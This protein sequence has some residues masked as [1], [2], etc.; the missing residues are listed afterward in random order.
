LILRPPEKQTARPLTELSLIVDASRFSKKIAEFQLIIFD[1]YA[2]QGVLPLIYFDNI[3]K[4]VRDGGAVLIAAGPLCKPDQH[5]GPRWMAFCL[6]NR[7]AILTERSF[8]PQLPMPAAAI[9]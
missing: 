6:P 3:A 2:R 9:R 1:R 8:Q 7:P 5:P 4:Y